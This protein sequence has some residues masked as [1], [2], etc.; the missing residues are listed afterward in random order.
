M[1][2]YKC[3]NCNDLSCETSICPVCHKRT[4]LASSD[5]FYCKKCDAPSFYDKCEACGGSCERI[6]SDIRPVFAKERLLIEII[7][8]QTMKFA[9]EQMWNIGPQKFFVAGHKISLSMEQ[10]KK[11]GMN[12][13]FENLKKYDLEK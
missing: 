7:L 9:G 11:V 1:I 2:T 10:M 13:I 3:I 8:G 4:T 5:I 6:G 12:K